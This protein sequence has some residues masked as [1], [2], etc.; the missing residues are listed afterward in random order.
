MLRIADT[1]FLETRNTVF[2]NEDTCVNSYTTE[3]SGG[4]QD[5]LKLKYSDWRQQIAD[6]SHEIRITQ[7]IIN[8][9][10]NAVK[11]TEKG[12]VTLSVKGRRQDNDEL[13]LEVSVKDTG[14]G[15]KNEDLDG[16]FEEFTR[17]D[18]CRNTM[19]KVQDWE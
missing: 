9:L 1:K 2:L 15:I 19:L 14:I 17:L 3:I 11:Y 12:K 8:I 6:M 7:I 5:F 10:T 16:L 18:V 4:R 13:A